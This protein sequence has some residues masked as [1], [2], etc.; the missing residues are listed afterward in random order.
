M[1]NSV[2]DDFSVVY[3]SS[4]CRV[5]THINNGKIY[6]FCNN[7]YEGKQFGYKA[8]IISLKGLTAVELLSHHYKSLCFTMARTDGEFI[9]DVYPLGINI[10]VLLAFDGNDNP[11]QLR[12]ILKRHVRKGCACERYANKYGAII[13]SDKRDDIFNLDPSEYTRLVIMD[14]YNGSKTFDYA[15]TLMNVTTFDDL[16]DIVKVFLSECSDNASRLFEWLGA[17]LAKK[18][19]WDKALFYGNYSDFEFFSGKSVVNS[20]L[21]DDYMP[22]K[23]SMVEFFNGFENLITHL[24]CN[25]GSYSIEELYLIVFRML[26]YI[27]PITE[28]RLHSWPKAPSVA[29]IRCT[30]SR[31]LTYFERLAALIPS[32]VFGYSDI[33]K[34]HYP[35]L[36]I[37]VLTLNLFPRSFQRILDYSVNE[38]VYVGINDMS[39]FS[40]YI[41]W[42]SSIS[43]SWLNYMALERFKNL[44]TEDEATYFVKPPKQKDFYEK[45][46]KGA[47]LFQLLIRRGRY[48]SDTEVAAA[49]D[50]TDSMIFKLVDVVGSSFINPFG[51][52]IMQQ[53]CKTLSN[54][55]YNGFLKSLVEKGVD[56]NIHDSF[57]NTPL[58]QSI[59]N[60]DFFSF[61][62]SHGA[63]IHSI[64]SDL[65]F[66][67][68]KMIGN[69]SEYYFNFSEDDWNKVFD[70]VDGKSFL[71]G[72]TEKGNSLFAIA[73]K[74]RNLGAI[75][76]LG[77]NGF[78]RADE[79]DK[80]R[81]FAKSIKNSELRKE[82]AGYV[83]KA[84]SGNSGG[85]K[86]GK[87]D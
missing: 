28:L 74:Y 14:F 37:A 15:L 25:A 42:S 36:E 50:G 55:S 51:Y 3:G 40:Q 24:E 49:E 19:I 76:Y 23:I 52:S 68:D 66:I 62:V 44:M 63:D 87:Q 75:H 86:D 2:I 71:F 70:S 33:G 77:K 78:V 34:G 72:L 58:K 9:P 73:V 11:I 39:I 53:A 18:C 48:F 17:D 41:W 4:K 47:L 46:E 8:D 69:F 12:R 5:L 59:Y 27:G 32:A 60:T 57:G 56:L 54:G 61:L 22:L 29:D 13:V 38:G 81:K 45:A 64:T 30:D 1:G 67:R 85:D 16:D 21:E 35:L 26:I 65:N 6:L 7:I 43:P 10:A 31:L 84:V 79:A 80:I 83:D 82:I 20:F